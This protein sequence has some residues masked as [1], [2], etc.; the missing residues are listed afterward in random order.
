MGA[1]LDKPKTDKHNEHGV[2][3]GLR[4][5]LASMQ[6]W[7]I[8]MED[9][10]VAVANLPG[11]LKDWA[12]FAVFDGHAGAKI[13]AHCSE[14]LLNSITSGEEFQASS[15]ADFETETEEKTINKIKKG[16]HAGFLRLDESMRLMPEVVSGEDKSGTTA[17]CALISPTHIFVANCG[18]S[19]GVLYRAGN[20]G[21]ST[22]DHKPVNPIEKERIQNAGG[23]VMIQRVNGSLA[24][25]R[26]LGDYEYKNV[27][28]KGPCEQLVSPEPE[29]YVERRQDE[30]EFLVLA[31]DGIWDVMT[32]EDLCAFVRSR[33]LL[34]EDHESISNHVVDTCLHKGSRDNMSLVLLTFPGAPKVSQEAIKKEKE[35]EELIEKKVTE[36]CEQEE[37]VSMAQIM[38]VLADESIPNLPPGGG[39][40]AKRGFVDQLFRKLRPECANS[41]PGLS[42]GVFPEGEVDDTVAAKVSG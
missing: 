28:G 13:S 42:E 32:N 35:L 10:H 3:N 8:E 33:L 12:F 27:E 14:H 31:C 29:I 34:S 7:R 24:V 26:A 19:R 30:D 22:Q 18:D 38:Q 21:F 1:F 41:L 37:P 11:V 15:I 4:Y 16:I 17:V 23:S 36:V 20:I 39:L 5:G 40:T 2:G 9:A 6:G 25:S